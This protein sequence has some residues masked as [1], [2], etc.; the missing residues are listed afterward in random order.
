MKRNFTLIILILLIAFIIAVV[1]RGK[2]RPLPVSKPPALGKIALV[3]DDWGYN[4][5]DPALLDEVAQPLTIS[6]LPNLKYSKHIAQWAR[7]RDYEVILHLPLEPEKKDSGLYSRLESGTILCS[8]SEKEVR[9]NFRKAISSVPNA[10]GVSNHMGS[11]ATQDKRLMKIIFE[12]MSRANLYFLD[13]L[14]TNKSICQDKSRQMNI[15]F[16]QRDVFLDNYSDPQYIKSQFHELKEIAKRRG[17]AIG[18]AHARKTTLRIIKEIVPQL[19]KEKIR[20]VYLS[21][22][23]H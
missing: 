2:E 16:A 14:V 21:E 12:E 5:T 23:V 3:I 9:D 10:E 11:K 19:E 20:F 22:L 7:K 1:L 8:M 18:V 17:Y 4:F 13:N 6:V 15:K